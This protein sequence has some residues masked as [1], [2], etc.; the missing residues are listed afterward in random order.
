MDIPD[1]RP[2]SDS[3]S[4]ESEGSSSPFVAETPSASD[5]TSEE[6]T[7]A[8]ARVDMLTLWG[9]ETQDDHEPLG[10]VRLNANET[11]V[12]PFTT[13]LTPVEIH[14]CAEPEI[15]GYVRCNGPDCI[16]C[17][18]GR[19][20]DQRFL[21]PVH[22]PTTRAVAVLA[23]SPSAKPGALRPQLL[24]I[25]KSG[26]RVAVSITRLDLVAYRVVPH[27]LREG[28]DDGAAIIADFNRRW[29]SHQI[30]LCAVYPKHDN[31]FL[32]ELPGVSVMM[33]FKGITV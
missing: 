6:A 32:A 1:E 26:K 16:L 4:E 15:K 12:I 22:L 24:A 3:P 33:A 11:M 17:R 2:Q 25:L 29:E 21:L 5:V 20:K 10:L 14:Y 31:A 8:P 19:N 13:D 30:E 23:I 27:A 18:I 9:A 7:D 28:I